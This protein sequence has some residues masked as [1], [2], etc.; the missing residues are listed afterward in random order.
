MLSADIDNLKDQ[1]RRP[2]EERDTAS[3][4][5]AHWIRYEWN[6]RLA[7]H[8]CD[9]DHWYRA[10]RRAFEDH[11][12][13]LLN[14]AWMEHEAVVAN[15]QDRA[16]GGTF[17]PKSASQGR[18]RGLQHADLRS[19]G[20]DL[21]P[22][23]KVELRLA[24]RHPLAR[25]R[26]E[27]KSVRPSR[28]LLIGRTSLNS[29]G[30]LMRAGNAPGCLSPSASWSKKSAFLWR[31]YCSPLIWVGQPRPMWRQ[32]RKQRQGQSACM[33]KS[34]RLVCY[35]RWQRGTCGGMAL[36]G[37]TMRSSP[38]TLW[39]RPSARDPVTFPC[40]CQLSLADVATV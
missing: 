29:V 7:E 40:H 27:L 5:A 23:G 18:T 11:N 10:E 6:A 2:I 4:D 3:G 15:R 19:Q 12:L 17:G 31:K 21:Q 35:C 1:V 13:R 34:G 20:G 28:L 30:Q 26:A 9:A 36:H 39:V 22:E 38:T 24:N 33:L 8:R 25:G 37:R 14:N 16:S 32:Q